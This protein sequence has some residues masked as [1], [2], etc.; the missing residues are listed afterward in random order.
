MSDMQSRIKVM[1]IITRFDKGGSAENTFLTIRYLD[2]ERYRITLV[3]GLSLESDLGA[4]E[5]QAVKN[6]LA[7]AERNGVKIVTIPELVRKIHPLYDFKAFVTL[8]KIFREERPHIVHTHTSKAGL[9]GRWAAFL[10]KIP[11]IIHTP[12][13]HVFWGYFNKWMT[14]FYIFLE[15]FTAHITDKI[16]TLNE[17]EKK[18]NLRFKIAPE[19]RFLSVHSGVDL[20]TFFNVSIDPAE[21]KMNLGIADN[22][23][24]VGT[25]GRLTSIK[26]HRYLIEAAKEIVA[27][28]HD[29]N[30]VF[31]GDGELLEGL[32]KMA[33]ELSIRKNVR[34]LGW[35]P[36]VA[37][38]IS[39][40][41]IFVLPSL[42][43][44]MG[45]VLV[46][47]MTL[48]KPIVASNIG[49][50]PDLIIQGENGLLVPVADAKALASGI[51]F[52][53]KNPKKRKE[54]GEKGKK[55]AA[56]YSLDSMMQKID[57]LYLEVLKKKKIL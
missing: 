31:L 25:V 23:F 43:E 35:R 15:R 19:D 52:L 27:T 18:D 10:A 34:F 26:G 45:K 56:S 42:N 17:H 53:L 36:D 55:I 37:E 29:I 57:Q 41:D 11:V 13:G 46:E 44:G 50:I 7:E 39:I 47:A 6:I 33:S 22:A 1:H 32:E 5:A 20:D 54:M 3:K 12:H 51:E 49:G 38:V 21:M 8:I 28:K 2:K 40:F 9:L 30:F 24:V 16:I 14:S 48:G 4:Q